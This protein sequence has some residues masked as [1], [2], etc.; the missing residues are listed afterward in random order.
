[1]L[2][3]LRDYIARV[4]SSANSLF[5]FLGTDRMN[6]AF[7]RERPVTL[8]RVKPDLLERLK[9]AKIQANWRT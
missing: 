7:Q 2:I 5:E 8:N 6:P 4:G 3:L 1:L 9:K